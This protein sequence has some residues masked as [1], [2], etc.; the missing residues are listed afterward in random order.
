MRRSASHPSDW[1]QTRSRAPG[2]KA[3]DTR[4]RA[5]HPARY[6]LIVDSEKGGEDEDN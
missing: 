2:Q 6:L 3:R 1:S 4:E 5:P